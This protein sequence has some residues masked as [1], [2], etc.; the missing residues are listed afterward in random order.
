[1]RTSSAYIA[2]D[3]ISKQLQNLKTLGVE[4]NVTDE[5]I[6]SSTCVLNVC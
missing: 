6:A 4:I 2:S 1:M 3:W 5:G